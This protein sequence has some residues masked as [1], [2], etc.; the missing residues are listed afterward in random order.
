MRRGHC[1]CFQFRA[2]GTLSIGTLFVRNF[3]VYSPLILLAI[4]WNAALPIGAIVLT[5]L[6][7][8]LLW[9]P[10]EYALHRYVF[11]RMAPHYQH[12]DAPTEREYIFAPLWFSGIAAVVLFGLFGLAAGSWQRGALIEAGT[13]AGYLCY[14]GVHF[15]IHS[16]RPGG[17]ILTALRRHHYYH[18]F[19]DDTK[20]YGVVTSFWDRVFGTLQ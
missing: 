2:S 17:A 1:G 13:V 18:H 5:F 6:L 8:L 12:H 9:T 7:G 14:E 10:L 11:H 19:A 20:C 16:P 15:W 4:A 3:L